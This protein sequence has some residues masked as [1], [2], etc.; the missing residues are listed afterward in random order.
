M[1]LYVAAA[2]LCYNA[3]VFIWEFPDKF[4]LVSLFGISQV[5]TS[6]TDTMA[7]AYETTI[8][9]DHPRKNLLEVIRTAVQDLKQ[10]HPR[11]LIESETTTSTIIRFGVNWLTWGE[12]ITITSGHNSIRVVSECVF[13]LQMIDWGKNRRNVDLVRSSLTASLASPEIE[14]TE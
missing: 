5:I 6:Y 9:T 1:I 12:R 7:A 8:T 11:F 14:A 2:R 13:P 4:A 3:D 10:H